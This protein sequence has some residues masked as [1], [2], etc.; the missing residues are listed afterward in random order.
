VDVHEIESAGRAPDGS[1]AAPTRRPANLGTLARTVNGKVEDGPP[2]RRIAD[3]LAISLET[4]QGFM[5]F[6]AAKGEIVLVLAGRLVALVAGL[7]A[8]LSAGAAPAQPSPLKAYRFGNTYYVSVRDVAAYYG[9]GRDIRSVV[10]RAEYKTSF[11]QL[12][13]Q[14]DR[15]DIL[16]NGVNHWLS[17]PILAERGRL[18][19]AELDV[20]KTLDP[21]LRPE[22][23][24]SRA[25]IRTIVID[26]GHGGSDRGTRGRTGLEKALTLDL[27][28]RLERDLAG[29]GV[30][31]V[32]TRTSDKTVSLENR[33]AFARAKAADLFVS[34]HFNSGGFADGIETYCAPPAGAR[35]T[36]SPRLSGVDREAVPSNRFDE[37]NV[38]LA[39]CTQ[40][41]L[42]QATGAVDR[43]VRR[44]RFYVLRHQSCPAILIEAG[45]LSNATEEQRILRTDYRE[46]LAK[47]IADGILTYRKSVEAR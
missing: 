24:R 19:M 36:A 39:H 14:A 7:F 13:L 12:E 10:D 8:S 15:R 35:S 6:C 23:L 31:V 21:V 41:A 42:F 3:R 37:Q 43:G 11:A 33:V 44:A 32:L 40:K 28:K 4:T 30:R 5:A 34:I 22:R 1:L 27:A 9:L 17:T 47:A 38:W 2:A 26:P 16:V 20:L 29:T 18:W 46:T 45:F 25:A